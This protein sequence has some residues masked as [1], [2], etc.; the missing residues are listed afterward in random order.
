MAA[1]TVTISG[2]KET[3]AALDDLRQHISASGVKVKGANPLRAALRQGANVI[4]RQARANVDAIVATPNIGGRDLST[5]TLKKAIKVRRPNRRF[6]RAQHGEVVRI[7][8]DHKIRYPV[9]RAGKKYN[10]ANDI[11]M[12]L[13]FG[14]ERRAPM[15]FMRP[16]VENKKIAAAQTF[17]VEFER[18]VQQLVDRYRAAIQ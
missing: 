4:M 18:R 2:L 11:A 10:R 8:V 13:E 7:Y 6:W 1:E 15:P 14:T 17:R 16:A 3:L 12:M 9:A 5:G